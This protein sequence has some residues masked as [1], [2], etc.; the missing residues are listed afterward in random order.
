LNYYS[1][2]EAAPDLTQAHRNGVSLA[3]NMT[4]KLIG[5]AERRKNQSES[6]DMK[7]ERKQLPEQLTYN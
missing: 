3:L 7:T 4:P 2:F 5:D 1:I 6:T